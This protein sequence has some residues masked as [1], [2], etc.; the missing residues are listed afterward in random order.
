MGDCKLANADEWMSIFDQADRWQ[1]DYLRERALNQLRTTYISPIPK[2][3]FWT[4]YHLPQADIIPSLIDLILR[5]DSLSLSEAYE[6]G[7]E[8]LVKLARARDMARDGGLCPRS[9]GFSVKRDE[10]LAR[11]VHMVFFS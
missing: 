6:L 2:I 8:M 11:I 10:A 9:V 1:M 3:V 7:L 5:P 4:R